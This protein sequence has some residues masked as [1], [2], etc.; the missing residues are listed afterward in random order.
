MKLTR[1]EA[2]KY[3]RQM[4]SDM[5]KELGDNPSGIDRIA[6]KSIWCEQH[7]PEECVKSDCFLCAYDDCYGYELCDFCPIDWPCKNLYGNPDCSCESKTNW[8][9]SPISKILALPE[10]ELSDD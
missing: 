3:H 2:L 9:T 1:E 5:Q 6:F 8:Y 7:F 4:W 10:R